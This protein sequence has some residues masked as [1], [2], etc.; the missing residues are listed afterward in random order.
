MN[1]ESA[2]IVLRSINANVNVGGLN[3]DLTFTGINIKTLLGSLWQ[4]YRRFKLIMTA[5]AAG[6][7]AGITDANRIVNVYM[8]GPRWFTSSY[9]TSISANR[10]RALVG[11]AEYTTTG[12]SLNYI[13]DS[14]F[15]FDNQQTMLDIRL[16][17]ARVSDDTVAAAQY[18][19]SIFVFSIYG[20][21]EV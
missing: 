18:P 1:L 10:S 8:E 3:N 14:G 4:K 6:P 17:I 13:N 20:V 7:Q 19:S 16:L 5:F 9:D 2:T 15:L 21:E 12:R 11:T